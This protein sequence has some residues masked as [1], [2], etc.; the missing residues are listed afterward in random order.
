MY[1]KL[2]RDS[3]VLE[4]LRMRLLK[5]RKRYVVG[6]VNIHFYLEHFN[7]IEELHTIGQ[8]IFMIYETSLDTY[9][10]TPIQSLCIVK[11]NNKTRKKT[12]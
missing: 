3:T 10:I 7:S 9:N 2:S 12:M 4:T 5:K 8:N 1:L 6:K 11:E